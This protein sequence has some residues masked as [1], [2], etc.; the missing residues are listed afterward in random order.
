MASALPLLLLG[1]AAV[2]LLGGKKKKKPS[3]GTVLATSDPNIMMKQLSVK[4]GNPDLDPYGK[5][6]AE[7]LTEFQLLFDLNI[8]GTW[9]RE[10]EAQVRKL[11]AE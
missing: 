7:I 2:L 9:T 1:G 11:L 5:N 8:T 6:L 3:R 4:M 10:T